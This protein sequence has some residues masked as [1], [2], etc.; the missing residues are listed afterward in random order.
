MLF[1]FISSGIKS[2]EFLVNKI[3]DYQ[4]QTRIVEFI[5]LNKIYENTMNFTDNDIKN[6]YEKNKEKFIE[7]YRSIKYLNINPQQL[8]GENSFNSLFFKKLDAIEDEIANSNNITFISQKFNLKTKSTGLFNLNGRNIKGDE[9]IDFKN[10]IINEIFKIEKNES[11][12][13]LININDDYLVVE[14]I[15]VENI[16][17]SINSSKTKKSIIKQL[18]KDFITNENK[19]LNKKIKNKLDFNNFAKENNTEVKI[20]EINN[21]NDYKK[22]NK[23]IVNKIYKLP[24]NKF[25]LLSDKSL[26]ENLLVYVNKINNKTINKNDEN[27]TNFLYQSNA[28]LKNDI[29]ATYDLYIN[30]KYKVDIN[31]QTLERIKNYYK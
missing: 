19:N 22:F 5:D 29:Y 9:E 31:Y 2:P 18:G 3:Y 4:N 11:P 23:D 10:E 12:V 16:S 14:L 20:A 24:K 15:N 7:N 13:V 26:N 30:K 28:K 1:D 8:V 25:G 17:S 6:Y 21:L 27:F